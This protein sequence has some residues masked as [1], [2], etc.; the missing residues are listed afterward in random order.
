[1]EK[2]STAIALILATLAILTD[3]SGMQIG[4]VLLAAVSVMVTVVAK[5]LKHRFAM[6]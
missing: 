5:T 1:V 3:Q 2:L 6:Y 4:T